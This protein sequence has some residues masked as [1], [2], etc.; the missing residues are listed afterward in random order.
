MASELVI[1]I[2][3]DM[4]EGY[5]FQAV[6]NGHEIPGVCLLLVCLLT[7]QAARFGR[8]EA[9]IACPHSKLMV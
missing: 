1:S 7:K 5:T 3:C 2:P 9:S 6:A 4:P 8:Q